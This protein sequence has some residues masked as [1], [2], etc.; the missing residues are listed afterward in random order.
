ML[1]AL[2]SQILGATMEF[3]KIWRK[4]HE[5]ANELDINIQILKLA[6]KETLRDNYPA[7]SQQEYFH[8]SIFIPFIDTLIKDIETH[9]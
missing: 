6:K 9:F 5:V 7:S 3:Y 4:S 1:S 2:K 8:L